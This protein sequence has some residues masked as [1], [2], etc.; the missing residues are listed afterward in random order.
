MPVA[1]EDSSGRKA[2]PDVIKATVTTAAAAI[3][4]TAKGI[5]LRRWDRLRERG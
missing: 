5:A 4:S 1:S 3:V 2:P